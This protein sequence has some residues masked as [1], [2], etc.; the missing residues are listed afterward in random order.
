ME[1]GRDVLNLLNTRRSIRKYQPQ[2]LSKE[3]L[4]AILEAGLYAPTGGNHQYSRFIATQN[5]QIL[6]EINQIVKEEFAKRDLEEGCYQNKTIVKA[7]KEGYSCLHQAPAL[8]IAVAPRAHGNSM[9][10]CANGLENMQIA[11]WSLGIGTCWINQIHWLTKNPRMRDFLYQLGMRADEDVFGSLVAGH[12]AEKREA[13][14]RKEGR[15]VI[16]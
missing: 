12:P 11:A 13:P 2:A 9:A 5:K 6:E 10:D 8:I 14:P 1:Q 3:Q 4:G 16:I 7:K 15:L